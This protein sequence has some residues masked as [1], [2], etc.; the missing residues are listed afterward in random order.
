MGA[1]R[2]RKATAS[3][4]GTEITLA[5]DGVSAHG[6][7]LIQLRFGSGEVIRLLPVNLPNADRTALRDALVPWLQ[8]R[9]S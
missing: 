1:K 9:L 2:E 4:F 7:R 5:P 6:D 3:T 8:Q